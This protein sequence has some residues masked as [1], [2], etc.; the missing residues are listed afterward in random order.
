MA[1]PLLGLFLRATSALSSPE[2]QQTAF[3]PEAQA[4]YVTSLLG[5]SLA[6][7][8]NGIGGFLVAWVLIRYD[9]PGK[10]WLD[11]AVDLPFSL[12]TSVAGLTLLSIYNPETGVLGRWLATHNIRV[13]FSPMAVLLARVF[14]SFPFVIRSVQP[15]LAELEP[16]LEEAALSLGATPFDVFR[17]VIW[18]ATKPAW[19]TGIAL[20]F[21]RAVGEFGSVVR[22]ASNRVF[23]DLTAP[24]LVFQSLENYQLPSAA[25]IGATR[26]ILSLGRLVSIN[27]LAI[28][29]RLTGLF[30]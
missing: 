29:K 11:A 2:A 28:S 21:A 4:A 6:A 22:L 16:E 10:G 26:L 20:A 12:P 1:L 9:F 23:Y 27:A 8:V 24:V 3:G 30:H 25:L 7:R 19:L 15:I 17:L 14:V 13:A 18:P 5:A